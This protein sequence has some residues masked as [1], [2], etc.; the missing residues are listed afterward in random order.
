VMC[1]PVRPQFGQRTCMFTAVPSSATSIGRSALISSAKLH[2]GQ[3][4]VPW[5]LY[6]TQIPYIWS[7]V[8]TSVRSTIVKQVYFEGITTDQRSLL[9]VY[10]MSCSRPLFSPSGK[11][12]GTTA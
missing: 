9:A 3:N 4:A 6:V 12:T 7:V 2:T 10:N 1:I 5:V 8:K 11:T